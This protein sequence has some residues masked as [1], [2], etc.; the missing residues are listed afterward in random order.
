[1][2]LPPFDLLASRQG[3]WVDRN[4][5]SYKIRTEMGIDETEQWDDK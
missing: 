3:I 1:M 2:I 4:F 5:H